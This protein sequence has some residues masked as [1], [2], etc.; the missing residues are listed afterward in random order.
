ME[1]VFLDVL[2]RNTF[3]KKLGAL[4]KSGIT[5]LH[6]YGKGVESLSLQVE[7]RQL[8]RL[9][10]RVGRTAPFTVR[11]DGDEHFVI[12][13][14]VQQHPVTER[15]LHVDL[16]QVSRTE[17][18]TVEVPMHFVGEAPA[19]RETGVIL[20]Q[21][22]YTLAVEALPFE[23]PPSIAVDV[24]GLTTVDMSIHAR[25]LELPA[26]VS[27]VTQPDA[28]IARISMPRV[29]AEPEAETVEAIAGEVPASAQAP[30]PEE[31]EGEFSQR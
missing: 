31:G 27:L 30:E 5:P 26:G 28:L 23:L 17:R 6:I 1:L 13:R 19:V 3:G 4:R 11:V 10:A 24:S 8:I 18:M 9:L 21:D 2:P 22:L 12:V 16:V 29:A 20:I 14:E 25:D 15:L 7:T